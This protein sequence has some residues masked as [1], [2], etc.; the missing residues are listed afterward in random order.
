MERLITKVYYTPTEAAV[1]WS[2]LDEQLIINT[3]IDQYL[4]EKTLSQWPSLHL[5]LQRIYDGILNSELKHGKN[6]INDDSVSIDD[7]ALTIRHIE[8]KK[9]MLKFYPTEKPPFLFDDYEQ[10]ILTFNYTNPPVTIHKSSLES[11]LPSGTSVGL[12]PRTETT[13]LSIIGAMLMIVTDAAYRSEPLLLRNTD[14]IISLILEHYPNYPGLSER[15]LRGKFSE[16]KKA[17]TTFR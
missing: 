12:H 16:A 6:G 8:L 7:P 1:F 5:N 10:K 2:N 14:A 13:Y 11:S 3:S 17:I 4:D 15:T 9:W